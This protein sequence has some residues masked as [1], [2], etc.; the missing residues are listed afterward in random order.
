MNGQ[1][2]CGGGGGRRTEEAAP[3][4]AGQGGRPRGYGRGCCWGGARSAC[5]GAWDA[6]SSD[7]TAPRRAGFA[8]RVEAIERRIQAL[9][10]RLEGKP[11]ATP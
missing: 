11:P 7:G 2:G 3:S 8:D 5:L 1:R 10:D 9:E 4:G 6:A